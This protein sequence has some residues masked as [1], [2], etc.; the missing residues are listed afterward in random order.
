MGLDPK[1]LILEGLASA[2]R[3]RTSLLGCDGIRQKKERQLAPPCS[4]P[5]FL[6]YQAG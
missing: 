4:Y 1:F 3:L 5:L 2:A 6:F